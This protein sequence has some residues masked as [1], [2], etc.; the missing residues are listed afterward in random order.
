MSQVSVVN[1]CLHNELFLKLRLIGSSIC[2]IFVG[3]SG[4]TK[5][6]FDGLVSKALEKLKYDIL[7]FSFAGIEEGIYYTLNRQS[8]DLK[9]VLD[10][11]IELKRYKELILVCTS[12]GAF[13]ASFAL[14]EVKY[15]SLISNAIFLDPADYCLTEGDSSPWNHIWPG[16]VAYQPNSPVA[17]DLLRTLTSNTKVHVVNFM[18]RNYGP[19]GYCSNDERGSDHQDM[20]SR[21]NNSMVKAFYLKAPDNNKGQYIEDTVLPHAFVRDGNVSSNELRVVELLQEILK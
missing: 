4:D 9:V 14:G 11:L 18:L 15:S 5:D 10:Y 21:L 8:D 16:Y 7:T 6:T 17:S 20:F 19:N 12:D 2:L 13:S 1:S 3:G